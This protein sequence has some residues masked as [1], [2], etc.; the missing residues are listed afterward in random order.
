MLISQKQCDV[1]GHATIL[2]SLQ[3]QAS[4]RS[5][6]RK[7]HRRDKRVTFRPAKT[8]RENTRL[9]LAPLCPVP[10]GYSFSARFT[11]LPAIS[12]PVPNAE[13]PSIPG[14]IDA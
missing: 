7:G 4:P 14:Q 6:L 12:F 13:M 11:G 2:S 3:V 8:D 5:D 9:D 10:P 1:N